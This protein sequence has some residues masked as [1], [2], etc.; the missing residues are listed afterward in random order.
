V[1]LR[2]R[3]R[4]RRRALGALTALGMMASAVAA[5]G[6]PAC[7][8]AAPPAD[9]AAVRAAAGACYAAGR[10]A[11]AITIY[12]AWLARAPE[13]RA[14]RLEVARLLTEAGDLAAAEAEYDRLLAAG[15]P[16]AE[17]ASLRKARADVR[18]WQGR[19]DAAIADYRA[20]VAERPGD[21][22][23]WL[24]LGLAHRWRGDLAEAEEVLARAVA[25]DPAS[26]PAATAL[27]ELR[28]SPA[29]RARRA[30]A[31]RAAHP[32]DPARW[33]A[34]AEALAG[35]ERFFEAETML[36]QARGR[37]PGDGRFAERQASLARE[38]DARLRAQL[39]E[40]RAALAA[41]AGD[42]AARLEAARTLADLGDMRGA[43]RE[44]E[45]HL[46]RRPEDT[47]ARR[48]LARVLSWAGD[49]RR[50]LAVYDELARAAPDDDELRLE[51]GRVLAWD[52]QLAESARTLAPLGAASTAPGDAGAAA[53]ARA[54]GDVYHWAGR[55]GAA[56]EYYREAI[57]LG[58]GGED[59]RAAEAFFAAEAAAA[60][61]GSA[62][63]LLQ[64][65]D[66][67]NALRASLEG[68]RRLGVATE[69][70]ARF[71]HAAY[72]QRGDGLHAERLR[73]E[74]AYDVDARWRV[75]AAYG[76]SVYD[77]G[78]STHAWS[79]D[80]ERGLG[81]ETVV[82]IGYDRYDI[83]DEVL[84]LDSTRPR[85]LEADRLRA[86]A[87]HVLPWRLE[88]A[89]RASWAAYGDGNA[90]TAAGGSLGRRV[91]RRPALTVR[92][93]L[94]YLSYAERSRRY[95]DPGRYLSHAGAATLAVGIGP[96]GRAVLDARLGWGDEDGRGSLEYAL[97]AG[98]E[99]APVG[100][101]S[102]E[103]GYRYGKSADIGSR[104]S[105]GG[106]SIHTASL[107]LHYR[108]GAR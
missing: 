89:A 10:P 44:Y 96:A 32:D 9:R 95:W 76:P 72:E 103:I 5:A 34:A 75:A 19:L 39:A 59:A 8:P 97:G 88:A 31:E 22:E 25:A 13:D 36:E 65:S 52:G 51:R 14:A 49:Y 2:T 94:A 3:W 100:G 105:G 66:G 24:G 85:V 99:T 35:A 82:A 102:A 40:A 43:A 107:A 28:A 90:L 46:E 62:L 6:A 64:D 23:A 78:R 60:E 1:S 47:T 21:A 17:S 77:D 54:L 83:I 84:T 29:W 48:Q 37:F 56:A 4:E 27:A 63:T 38:K 101:V 80:L 106:Y 12:R 20:L 81:P 58:G 68:R 104:R 7:D 18:A 57:R 26:E 55:R 67:F 45:R 87:R 42:D 41:D 15:A 108:W 73:L 30:E 98:V 74:A 92:Y 91:L 33:A 86:T 71:T 61:L 70:G 53:A 69:L 93:D 16:A 79:L 11:A 50:A